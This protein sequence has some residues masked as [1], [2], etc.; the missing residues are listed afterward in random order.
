MVV[1]G[2][3]TLKDAE[4][5]SL[6]L[7]LDPKGRLHKEMTADQ[8]VALSYN[9]IDHNLASSVIHRLLEKDF[10]TGFGPRTV[11]TTNALY[12]SPTY[13]DG[14]LGGY[15]TRASLAHALL[16]YSSGYPSIAG[17]QLEKVSRLMH[18]EC[19]KHGRRPRR[20]PLL[21]GPREEDHRRHGF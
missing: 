15:W 7:N 6:A 12:Y 10:E 5:G 20:V 1:S 21:D 17:L 16:A 2:E 8:A 4:S 14:Q 3:L 19:E 9:P 11:P 18:S 13:G